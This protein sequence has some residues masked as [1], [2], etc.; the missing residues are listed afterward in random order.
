M[1]LDDLQKACWDFA[2]F[3]SSMRDQELVLSLRFW[4]V[5]WARDLPR[6]Q[7]ITSKRIDTNIPGFDPLDNTTVTGGEAYQVLHLPVPAPHFDTELSVVAHAAWALA[8]YKGCTPPEI[9]PE[10]KYT[11]VNPASYG[12]L[13]DFQNMMSPIQEGVQIWVPIERRKQIPELLSGLGNASDGI[14]G[15]EHGATKA[16]GWDILYNC[17]LFRGVFKQ[18]SV[19]AGC[20]ARVF[21]LIE[22]GVPQQFFKSVYAGNIETSHDYGLLLDIQKGT[23]FIEIQCT[24]NTMIGRAQVDQ[25]FERFIH[26]FE[27]IVNGRVETV[28]DLLPK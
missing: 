28:G 23:G 3:M 24:W 7:H 2:Y 18:D 16:P 19:S 21:T 9:A 22:R 15:K 11:S 26:F 13:Q 27:A 17:M 25:M 5:Y 4:D 8:S 1:I 6:Q 12:H 10:V 14:I 20:P